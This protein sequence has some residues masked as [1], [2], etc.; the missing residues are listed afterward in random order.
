M[1]KEVSSNGLVALHHRI[2]DV[3]LDTLLINIWPVSQLR[4]K[5][6]F[7]CGEALSAKDDLAA[8]W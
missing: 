2:V 6:D 8:I 3:L 4:G 5:Q 1:F 7:G